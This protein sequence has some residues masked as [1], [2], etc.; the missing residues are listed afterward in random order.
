MKKA[1]LILSIL[2]SI[3][4]CK[5]DTKPEGYVLN[6]IAENIAD[7]SIVYLNIDNKIVDSAVV[8]NEKFEFQ[9]SVDGPT[10]AVLMV[11]NTND[12]KFIWLENN[13]ID[14]IG[15]KGDFRNSTIEGSMVQKDSDRL[16]EELAPIDKKR[17]SLDVLLS[18]LDE[19]G[20]EE[21]AEIVFAQYKKTTTQ[22]ELI[23]QAF[24]RDN[25]S[26]PVSLYVL[27]AYKTTWGKDVTK[28]LFGLLDE[29]NRN[30]LKGR[31][32]SRYIE[33]YGNPQIGENYIDFEQENV[34]GKMIKLSDVLNEYTLIE[35]WASWCGPCRQSNPE[36]VRL[37]NDYNDIGFEIIGVSLDEDRN[38]WMKAIEKD[39]LIW[40]NV[41]D[42][43]GSENEG[44]LRYSVKGIPD[45]ILIDKDGIIIARRVTP[46]NL[47]KSFEKKFSEQA[48]M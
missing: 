25:P 9:G 37:Y 31:S 34:D 39:K 42:L 26:S 5:T 16:S 8:K 43:K 28:D 46:E 3:L 45:N 10:N 23:N 6:G 1:A 41:S 48:N 18:Q 21:N 38:R 33:I 20:D 36:L 11:K 7:N 13:E 19:D 30:S 40:P 32:I 44:A 12:Y 27:N 4:A 29:E 35:F 47:R 2:L 17:D 24:V 15:K 22:S 14:F